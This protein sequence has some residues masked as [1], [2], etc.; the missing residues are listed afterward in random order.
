M[1]CLKRN[2][3]Q[4]EDVPFSLLNECLLK[5]WMLN[6]SSWNLTRMVILCHSVT[7]GKTFSTWMAWKNKTHLTAILFYPNNLCQDD[8]LY[9]NLVCTTHLSRF[10]ESASPNNRLLKINFDSCHAETG[11]ILKEKKKTLVLGSGSYR[12]IHLWWI[13]NEVISVWEGCGWH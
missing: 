8:F 4:D 13:I 6:E 3:S 2:T 1:T 7:C 9:C 11:T 12:F 10:K 5:N